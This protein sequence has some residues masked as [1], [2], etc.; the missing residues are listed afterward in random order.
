MPLLTKL[1][2]TG[3]PETKRLAAGCLNAVTINKQGKLDS[4][5]CAAPLT[6]LLFD[7]EAAEGTSR[8]TIG[9]LKNISE[10]PA[11]RKQIDKI[12]KDKGL[13]QEMK[14]IFA[15]PVYDHEQWPASLRYQHQNVAPGGEASK[16]EATQRARWAYPEPFNPS[17]A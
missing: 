4:V 3:A 5:A 17:N 13:Q 6:N 15:K 16:A 7:P 1:V 8:V 9:S 14:A 12:V 11:A 10:L 2:R